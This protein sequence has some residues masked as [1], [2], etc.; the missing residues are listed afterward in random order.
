MS[1][2]HPGQSEDY[3]KKKE[4][5]YSREEDLRLLRL[6]QKIYRDRFNEPDIRGTDMNRTKLNKIRDEIKEFQ[7]TN[8]GEKFPGED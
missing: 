2:A 7:K 5:R 8:P 3:K 1:R 4:T 6:S